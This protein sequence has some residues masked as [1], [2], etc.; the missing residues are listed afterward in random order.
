MKL[1]QYNEKLSYLNLGNENS[2]LDIRAAGVV[3]ADPEYRTGQIPDGYTLIEFFISGRAYI[4]ETSAFQASAGDLV[5]LRG[6]IRTD[7]E[8]D[9][10]IH[11]ET[12]PSSP[13]EKFW[14]TV[15]GRFNDSMLELY[16]IKSPVTV[17]HAPRC[18]ES[19]E[20]LIGDLSKFGYRRSDACHSLLSVYETAF[21]GDQD[22][23]TAPLAKRIRD[24]LDRHIDRPLKSGNLAAYF[25]LSERHLERVFEAE[26]GV[27]IFTYLRERRFVAACR[28]LRSSDELVYRIASRYQ[29][30]G[31]SHFAREFTERFGVSPTGYR[32]RFRGET[33]VWEEDTARYIGTIY[34]GIKTD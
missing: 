18:G 29:L 31:S 8:P 25:C 4:G 17:I 11:Y 26:F 1:T 5:I 20:R 27:T 10:N 23:R 6:V 12:D 19:I 15:K 32:E 30:G 9:G 33:A 21:G 22:E 24:V 34:D 7:D 13:V 14:L 16:S 28:E 3:S 2:F